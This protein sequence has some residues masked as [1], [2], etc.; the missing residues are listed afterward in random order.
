[1]SFERLDAAQLVKHAFGLRTEGQRRRKRP[2]LLYLFVEP[3]EWP[4][5]RP[6]DPRQVAKHRSEAMTFAEE[7][8]GAEVAFALCSYNQLLAAFA[9]SPVPGVREHASSVMDLLGPLLDNDGAPT[10]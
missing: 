7:V 6:I 9:A 3:S 1:M 2:I 10:Q 4:D 8:K 5:G